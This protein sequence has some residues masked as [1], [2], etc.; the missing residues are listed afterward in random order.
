M[1]SC[2]ITGPV[3]DSSET[4]NR[5]VYFP[6][7]LVLIHTLEWWHGL[8]FGLVEGVGDDGAVTELDLA[9]GLLLEGESVLHP[10]VVVTV[11]VV[12]TG[13]SATRLL[14]VGSRNGSLGAKDKSVTWPSIHLRRGNPVNLRAGEK[15]L[16]LQGLNKVRVPNHAA[17]LDTD[18]LEHLVYL[19]DLANT[20]IQTLLHTEHTDISLH[21]L[22]HG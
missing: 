6:L 1:T 14:A 19:V 16:E 17:V 7:S 2:D 13:V 4:S 10:V 18:I 20:L 5:I 11:G 21:G 22:L 12:L 9:V 15:V 8:A 3:F